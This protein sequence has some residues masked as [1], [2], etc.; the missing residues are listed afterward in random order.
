MMSD[1]WDEAVEAERNPSNFHVFFPASNWRSWPNLGQDVGVREPL[2][3]VKEEF[4][5]AEYAG[6]AY[7]IKNRGIGAGGSRTAP[8]G[9]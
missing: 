5:K 6:L 1:G 7:G 2:L 9:I 3:A 8:M 4:N